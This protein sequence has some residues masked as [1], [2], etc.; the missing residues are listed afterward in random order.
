MGIKSKKGMVGKGAQSTST[1]T[2]S[3]YAI[4]RCYA[5]EILPYHFKGITKNV[6]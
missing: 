1:T 5:L 2:T 3:T 4:K 6:S